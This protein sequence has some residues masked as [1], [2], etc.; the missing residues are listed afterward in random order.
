MTYFTTREWTDADEWDYQ[1]YDETYRQLAEEEQRRQAWEYA[2]VRKP[3]TVELQ[4][5]IDAAY[6]AFT[7]ARAARY[8]VITRTHRAVEQ[9]DYAATPRL[10]EQYHR[11]IRREWAARDAYQEAKLAYLEATCK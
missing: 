7:R 4:R 2:T 11:A 5:A 1:G 9:A 6:L 3:D 8:A 10:V